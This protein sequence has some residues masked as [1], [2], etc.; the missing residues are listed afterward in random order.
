MARK[1]KKYH[2]IYKTTNLINGKFY[3]GM[4]S[5]SNMNDGYLGSGRRLR[6]SIRKYGVENFQIEYLEF[7]DSREDLAAREAELVN[8]DLLHDPMCINLK[9]GGVGGWSVEQQRKNSIKGNLKKQWL[10]EN[11]K[12]WYERWQSN[13]SKSLKGKQ[14]WWLGKTHSDETKQKISETNSIQQSGSNNSQYGTCWITNDTDNKKIQK[15]DDI[16]TGW[17]LGRVIKK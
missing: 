16:P 2:Y 5:T 12:E 9:S 4:H 10:I 15:G 7:F 14:N 3:V 13:M 6:Y 8:E 1:A 17:K 11:D